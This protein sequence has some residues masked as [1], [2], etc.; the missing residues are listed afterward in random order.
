MKKKLLLTVMTYTFIGVLLSASSEGWT[1]YQE[2]SQRTG[3]TISDGPDIPFIYWEADL[4][5]TIDTTPLIVNDK[6]I[7]SWKNSFQTTVEGKVLVFNLPTGDLMEKISRSGIIFS[8][9]LFINEHIIGISGSK[10]CEIDL[11]TK[12]VTILALTPEKGLRI[13]PLILDNL[14]VFPTIP[15]VC[16]SSPDFIR[17][18]EMGYLQASQKLIPYS[19]AGDESIV[20][21][22]MAKEGVTRLLAVD[23]STGSI[24]WESDPLPL[25][26]WAAINEDTIYCGGEKLWAYDKLGKELWHF[27]PDER[28]ASNMVVGPDAIYIVDYSNHLY[29]IGFDGAL[30]WKTDCEVSPWYYNT[31]LMGAGHILYCLRNEGEPDLVTK[32]SIS[33]FDM[34]NGT[35]IWE[36]ESNPPSNIIAAPIVAGNILLIVKENGTVIALASD[37]H[38]FE[39]Q[40]DAF[41]SRE[42]SDKAAESYRKAS[43][44][45]ERLGNQEKV[46]EMQEKISQLESSPEPAISSKTQSLILPIA[47]ILGMV[48]ISILLYISLIQKRLK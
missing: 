24:R 32:S 7:I 14:I 15:P 18:W 28:I 41:L 29:K 45:Y 4:G 27:A 35:E 3:Y 25:S 26:L 23:P 42:L 9:I 40:G 30:I 2:D 10:I 22:I 43:E 36:F 17:V 13:H 34:N 47:F 38:L 19:L 48:I 44:L 6:V 12:E 21:F 33:A 39:Q 46:Q 16:F 20:V 37:P 31:H 1:D 8:G 5:G 11:L